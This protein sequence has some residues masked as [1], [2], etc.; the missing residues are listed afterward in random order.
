[1]LDLLIF[2]GIMV[3]F[4]LSWAYLAGVDRLLRR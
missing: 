2:F 4:I 1:M 3:F